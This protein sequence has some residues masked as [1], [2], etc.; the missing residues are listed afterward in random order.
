MIRMTKQAD[1]GIVLLTH[2]AQEPERQVNAA[3]LSAETKLPA[4]TVSKILKLLARA[5]LLTSHRGVKGGYEL[6]RRA[7]IIS[8]ADIITALDGPIAITECVEEAPGECVQEP[9]CA[10]RGNWQRINHAIRGALEQITLAE[11]TRNVAPELVT[12]GGATP[13]AG[14]EVRNS[15]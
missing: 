10:V 3:V 14:R 2:M 12:L 8:V 5:G 4:P 1:Y 15:H 11:M 6:A 9:S 13:A 7:E